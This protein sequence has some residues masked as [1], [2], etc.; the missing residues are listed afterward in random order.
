MRRHDVCAENV[1]ALRQMEIG[2]V[3]I[4]DGRRFILVGLE[5]MSVPDRRAQIEDAESG[6]LL[7]VPVTAL[8]DEPDSEVSAEGR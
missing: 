6:E 4:H 5:P 2:D 8:S 7:S 3:I 1:F